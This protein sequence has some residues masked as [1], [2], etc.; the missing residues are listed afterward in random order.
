MGKK[1]TIDPTGVPSG[2]SFSNT[3]NRNLDRLADEFDKVIYRDGSQALTGNLDA[4]GKRILNLPAPVSPTDPVRLKD[5]TQGV[6][7]PKGDPGANATAVGRFITL[8]GNVSIPAGTDVVMT[9]GHTLDGVGQ[10]LY[11]YDAAVDDVYVSQ[12][13][14]TSFRT[15]NNRGFKLSLKQDISAYMF[16]ALDGTDVTEAIENWSQFVWNNPCTSASC[17]VYQGSLSRGIVV[18]STTFSKTNRIAF[19]PVLK[20]TAEMDKMVVFQKCREATIDLSGMELRGVNNFEFKK[21]E[22]RK[23]TDRLASIGLVVRNCSRSTFFGLYKINNMR[24][25]AQG[26]EHGTQSAFCQFHHLFAFGCGSNPKGGANTVETATWTGLPV[27]TGTQN[28]VGQR[29]VF[30]VDHV[31]DRPDPVNMPRFAKIG[32]RYYEITSITGT[33]PSFTLEVKHWVDTA[34]LG[35]STGTIEY[36]YGGAVGIRDNDN[37]NCRWRVVEAQVCGIIL[38][39]ITPY[40]AI[41]DFVG[42]HVNELVY[43]SQNTRGGGIL[44]GYIESTNNQV[45]MGDTDNRNLVFGQLS[46]N[47]IQFTK[48]QKAGPTDNAGNRASQNMTLDFARIEGHEGKVVIA[49][50]GHTF[51]VPVAGQVIPAGKSIELTVTLPSIGTS[52]AMRAKLIPSAA[53]IFVTAACVSSAAHK[54]TVKATIFNA[55]ASDVT[56]PSGTL[57]IT[58]IKD[59]KGVTDFIKEPDA[60]ATEPTEPTDTTAP[61][62]TAPTGVSTG[63]TTGTASVSTNE[64]NGTLYCALTTTATVPTVATI[65]SGLSQTV[66]STGTKSFSLSNLTAGTTY[67]AHFYHVDAA[68]NPS[69][70]V[71]STGFTTE[72]EVGDTVGPTLSSPTG[73]KTGSTTASI[74]VST[75]EGNGT[76]WYALSTTATTMTAA[77]IK[78][79]NRSTAIGSTGVKTFS[80]SDLTGGTTYYANFYQEDAALNPS[81][82]VTSAA[83][84]TDAT[85]DTTPPTLSS[86]TATKSG[87]TTATASVSTNEANGTLYCKHTTS[88]ATPDAATIMTG[89]SQSVTSTGTKSFGLTGLT[90]GT[91]YYAHFYHVDAAGNGSLRVSS[92]AFTTDSDTTTVAP[93]LSSPSGAPSPSLNTIMKVSVT[94]DVANGVMYGVASTSS[95]VPTI[96]QITAKQDHLG[97]PVPGNNH[98]VSTTGVNEFLIENLNSS[99]TYYVHIVQ[100]NSSGTFGNT[101]TTSAVSM[102]GTTDTVAPVLSAPTGVKTGSTSGTGGA[103]T[104]EGNG[105]MFV[106]ASTSATK[107]SASQIMAGQDHLGAAIPAASATI[108]STGA[109]SLTFSGLTAST[110][111]YAHVVHKDAAGNISNI[112]SSTAFTTDASGGDTVAPTLTLPTGNKTGSTTATGGATTDEANGTMYVVATTSAT[113]PTALQIEAGQNEAGVTTPSANAS[114]TTTGAQSVNIAG[115]TGSTTY[116]IHVMHKDAA[117]NRSNIVTSAAFTTD[118]STGTGPVIIEVVLTKVTSSATATLY[119][120]TDT[121]NGNMYALASTSSTPP[122]ASTIKSS[123]V[124]LDVEA[125]TTGRF[126]VANLS[127]STTYYVHVYQESSSGAASNIKT[128]AAFTTPAVS[129]T[130]PG[131]FIYY[132]S[133]VGHPYSDDW[134][135]AADDGVNYS[136]KLSSLTYVK[137]ALHE[138]NHEDG[139]NTSE[140]C[141]FYDADFTD[142]ANMLIIVESAVG[143][144]T[145]CQDNYALPLAKAMGRMPAIMR[146]SMRVSSEGAIVLTYGGGTEILARAEDL[147]H[148]ITFS[149]RRFDTR[150]AQGRLEEVMFHELVHAT[151]QRQSAD[152]KGYNYLKNPDGTIKQAWIDATTA[153]GDKY[154]TDRGVKSTNAPDYPEDFAETGHIAYVLKYRPSRIPSAERTIIQNQIPNKLAYFNNNVFTVEGM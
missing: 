62:L 92:A 144:Q 46:A 44:S 26:F 19:G 74:S 91:T 52:Q 63:S 116:Y 14:N 37:S 132:H 117:G 7:G 151:L 45:F 137:Q 127:P 28:S 10:A 119:A 153:D 105:T 41:I 103:T 65:M 152:G 23:V 8:N 50:F 9:S 87:T 96:S 15:T 100:K 6:Q 94:T 97:N 81:N 35:L 104:D 79:V 109:K 17:T 13:P 141:W 114:V 102:G 95:S 80:V 2:S 11:V 36:V 118:A 122:A 93:T 75:N 99:S 29:T 38:N 5:M 53:G 49:E 31:P 64:G 121:A 12:N 107:P 73:A 112:V 111:Y 133:V 123:G 154:A 139:P 60:P 146:K 70:I 128:S 140:L 126:S 134:F 57:S 142:I 69:D 98:A 40:G 89:L 1:I 129:S 149:K 61:T 85:A 90:A 21:G 131:Q 43:H 66:T 113:K 71:S 3:L 130:N 145:F 101:V 124:M 48:W 115:L 135:T 30:I 58:L 47:F 24:Y 67:Y 138:I 22:S 88:S 68:G 120:N 150:V 25:W 143:T 55:T 125:T 42:S 86:P 78:S 20:A 59:D 136:N 83:F 148:W 56:I 106:V 51:D 147:G 4:N 76:L 32:G 27:K 110:S 84:T 72:A 108:S 82:I 33:A 18:G 16:G 34:S 54:G 39:D 77:D